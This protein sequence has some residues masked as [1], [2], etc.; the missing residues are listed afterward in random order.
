MP[1]LNILIIDD[2]PALRQIVAA[3]LNK[4]GYTVDQASGV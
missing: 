1:S 4:A 3:V 2:E